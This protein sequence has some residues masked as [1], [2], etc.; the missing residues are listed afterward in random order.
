MWLKWLCWSIGILVGLFLACLGLGEFTQSGT[1]THVDFSP[2]LFTHRTVR[3]LYL[4]GYP[5]LVLGE[6]PWR[7]DLDEYLHAEGFVPGPD[8]AEPRWCMIKGFRPGVRGWSGRAKS[9][10]REAR[11][12]GGES[13]E[14]VTWSEQH[15]EL[16]ARLWPKVVALV[17]RE[18]YWNAAM[19]L[20]AAEQA[21]PEWADVEALYRERAEPDDD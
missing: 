21:G 11:C 4:L 14:W 20:R 8:T 1:A 19:A 9:F 3:E 7:T 16:S 15:P 10:C 2:D 5:I 12:F 17:R 18:S 13:E 6:R